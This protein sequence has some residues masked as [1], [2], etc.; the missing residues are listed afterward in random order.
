[1]SVCQEWPVPRSTIC[2]CKHGEHRDDPHHDASTGQH[3]PHF[4]HLSQE[5]H[6]FLDR[7]EQLCLVI[8]HLFPFHDSCCKDPMAS[9]PPS[10]NLPWG[11]G[12]CAEGRALGRVVSIRRV[13][14]R[15]TGQY[16]C[17]DRF[18]V[19]TPTKSTGG[20]RKRVPVLARG[21]TNA[22][23]QPRPP[24]TPVQKLPHGVPRTERVRRVGVA[25]PSL[26]QAA[27][28]EPRSSGDQSH[29]WLAAAQ[30]T[31]SVLISISF[32]SRKR[33]HRLRPLPPFHT[34]HR[35]GPARPASTVRGQG[36]RQATQS[37]RQACE[38]RTKGMP[39]DAP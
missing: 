38:H 30:A 8:G 16:A 23:D 5:A 1:M 27:S 32:I 20:M 33:R 15:A 4:D 26:S 22:R 3:Q 21:I 31:E 36:E 39:L 37:T 29:C 2:S 14:R 28:A 35:H 25:R 6:V 17:P 24:Y 19:C 18:T 7:F 13:R 11:I 34:G 10:D 12:Y 9:I